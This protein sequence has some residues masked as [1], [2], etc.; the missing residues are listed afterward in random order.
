VKVF[1][2]YLNEEIEPGINYTSEAFDIQLFSLRFP[3]FLSIQPKTPNNPRLQ[4]ACH[5]Q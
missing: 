5:R 1:R 3:F 4:A 2:C